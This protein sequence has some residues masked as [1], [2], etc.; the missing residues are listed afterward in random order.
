VKTPHEKV[1]LPFDAA[2]EFERLHVRPLAGPTLIVGSKI[3]KTREDR[4]LLY[5]DGS[6]IGVDMQAGP[7]VDVVLDLEEPLHAFG[8]FAHVECISVLEHS[9]RPWI[10]AEN[11]QHLMRPGSTIHVGVPFIWREHAYPSDY[12]RFTTHGVRLLFPRIRWAALTYGNDRLDA[13]MTLMGERRADGFRT[14][15]RTEVY[16][17]GALE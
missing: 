15:L 12:F 17:F 7:G 14:F 3:N 9:R 2:A 8:P 4:R 13:D 1:V 5:P 16:G 10:L 11:L 6:A